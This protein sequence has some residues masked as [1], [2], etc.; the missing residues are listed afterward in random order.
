MNSDA[1]D[2]P[3]CLAR[4][5]RHDEVAAR[6]LVERLQGQVEKIVRAHLP[7]REDLEDLRQEVFL[8]IFTRLGQFRGEVPF[9]HWVARVAVRTCIDRLRAHRSRPGVRWTDLSPEERETIEALSDADPMEGRVDTHAWEL[10]ERLLSR[11]PPADRL[12]ITWLDLDELSIREVGARTGW[13]AGVVR[14]RA[15]RARRRLKAL[16]ASLEP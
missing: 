10:L 9:E 15:F 16:F 11:L 2:W 14:I 7:R 5:R 1:F 6:A 4:V 3:D 13:S 8:K 12:L